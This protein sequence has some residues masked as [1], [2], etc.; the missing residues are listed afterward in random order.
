MRDA[1]RPM[2]RRTHRALALGFVGLLIFG[3]GMVHL[4]RLWLMQRKLDRRLA[5]LSAQQDRLKQEQERLRSDPTYLEGLIRSTFKVAKPGEVV[6][7]VPDDHQ[8]TRS[9]GHR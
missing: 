9:P 4:A 1:G 5:E 2:N 8:V 7:P 6:I 3:P